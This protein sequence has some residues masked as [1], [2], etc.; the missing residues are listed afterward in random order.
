MIIKY[1]Q[2]FTCF[3]ERIVTD[4]LLFNAGICY[5]RYLHSDENDPIWKPITKF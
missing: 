3:I 1:N 2:I 5:L 4:W